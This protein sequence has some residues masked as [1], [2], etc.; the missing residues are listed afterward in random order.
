MRSLL[1]QRIVIATSLLSLLIAPPAAS[2]Q[3]KKRLMQAA[4]CGGGAYGGVK[5]GEK[6][7]EIEAKKMKLGAGEAAKHRRAFQIGMALAL[8]GGGALVAGTVYDKMSKRDMEA[9]KR[10]IEAA[11]ENATPATRSYILPD[12]KL[13]GAIKTEAIEV[14]G[15]KE[16]RTVVDTLQEGNEP[17]RTRFC[18]KPPNGNFE[19]EL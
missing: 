18:R 15:S 19:L 5:L 7:A 13:T 1:A 12:S 14:D 10:E 17:A 16:C 2:A 6:I 11:V 4:V 8:C 3:L 9:R